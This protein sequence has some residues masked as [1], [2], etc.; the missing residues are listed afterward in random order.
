MA[1]QALERLIEALRRLPGVGVRSAQRMAFHL[2]QHDREGA[3]VRRGLRAFRAREAREDSDQEGRRLARARLGL[4]EHGGGVHL[5]SPWSREQLSGFEEDAGALFPGHGG[6][7]FFG[8]EGGVDGLFH[9]AFV[10]F[11]KMA[12]NMLV[13]VR[14]T[15]GFLLSRAHFFATD[16]HGDIERCASG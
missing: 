11:V 4:A 6:P 2:L 14:R 15:D 13:V 10:T 8:A 5:I 16:I 9:M 7:G 3:R 12:E 1:E